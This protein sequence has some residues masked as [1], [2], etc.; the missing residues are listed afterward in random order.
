MSCSAVIFMSPRA[1]EALLMETSPQ[2]KEASLSQ[3]FV[4]KALLAGLL[5]QGQGVREGEKSGRRRL[6]FAQ[7][8]GRRLDIIRKQKG[9]EGV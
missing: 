6:G 4:G 1:V 9:P 2:N 8:P 5:R 7:A 3:L